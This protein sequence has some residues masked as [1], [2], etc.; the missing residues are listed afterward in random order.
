MVKKAK[1]CKRSLWNILENTQ[2]EQIKYRGKT[3]VNKDKNV[4][5]WKNNHLDWLSATFEARF[6]KF[7]WA[8][9]KLLNKNRPKGA[10]TNYVYKIWLFLTTYP[11]RLHFLWYKCFQKIDFFDLL[12]PSSCKRSL[13][14]PPYSDRLVIIVVDLCYFSL[15]EDFS[16]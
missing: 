12:P 9:K 6:F 3:Q 8:K 2:F 4:K 7:S 1:S 13:W 15:F 16:L 10:F 5:C 11:L 14:T